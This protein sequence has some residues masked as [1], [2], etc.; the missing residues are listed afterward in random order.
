M[1]FFFSLR[2]SCFRE[3]EELLLKFLQMKPFK[4]VILGLVSSFLFEIEDRGSV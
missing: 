3:K 1:I 2:L 4:S